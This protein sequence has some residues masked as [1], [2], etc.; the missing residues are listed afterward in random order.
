[1]NKMTLLK[2]VQLY[3]E[4]QAN[5]NK[6]ADNICKYE[7]S[8]EINQITKWDDKKWNGLMDEFGKCSD[9]YFQN[10]EEIKKDVPLNNKIDITICE[11]NYKVA[12]EIFFGPLSQYPGED[13]LHIEIVEKDK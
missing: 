3:L 12:R 13:F 2:K 11:K 8:G 1:M 4:Y 9:L 5:L 10:I 7:D 6:C